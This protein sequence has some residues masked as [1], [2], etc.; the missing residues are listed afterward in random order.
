MIILKNIEQITEKYNCLVR[1]GAT[2]LEDVSA[3]VE[4]SLDLP[5]IKEYA[6]GLDLLDNKQNIIEDISEMLFQLRDFLP[7]VG[8]FIKIL[9]VSKNYEQI[10]IFVKKL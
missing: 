10:V 2:G 5:K 7:S 3:F 6:A 1:D 9:L 4:T 8:N